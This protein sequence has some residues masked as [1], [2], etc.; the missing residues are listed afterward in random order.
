[1]TRFFVFKSTLFIIASAIVLHGI[2]VYCLSRFCSGPYAG[3][4]ERGGTVLPSFPSLHSTSPTG[5]KEN[6]IKL[7]LCKLHYTREHMYTYA[8][9][10][11]NIYYLFG[12]LKSY[13][14]Y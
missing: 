11:I 6:V 10:K 14:M 4:I 13:G 5:K 12:C 1:M 2:M 8:I 9:S 7:N 3:L